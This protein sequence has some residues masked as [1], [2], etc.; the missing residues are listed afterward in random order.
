[1]QFWGIGGGPIA[2]DYGSGTVRFGNSLD[3]AEARE[4]VR[5]LKA[6][7]SFLV[8]RPEALELNIRP[9]QRHLMP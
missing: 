2:F 8:W 9:V 5:E 4:V 7:Y 1:M 6:R 3:E